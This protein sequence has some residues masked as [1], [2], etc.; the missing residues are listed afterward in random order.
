MLSS[1]L[2]ASGGRPSSLATTLSLN[3]RQNF[4]LLVK[5]KS[6]ITAEICFCPASP[7]SFPTPRNS[8]QTTKHQILSNN[9][10]HNRTSK[11]QPCQRL[12]QVRRECSHSSITDVI[13]YTTQ[14]RSDNQTP[15]PIKQP[16]TQPYPEDLTMSTP[17]GG[18][19]QICA[20]LL[21]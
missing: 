21:V 19:A 11:I 3:S 16:T 2:R 20:H 14:L 7:M 17:R 18:V 12:G 9:Q 1:Q 6:K 10:P 15:N 5:H 8:G 13:P 4:K